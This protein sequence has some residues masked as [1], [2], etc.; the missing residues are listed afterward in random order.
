MNSSDEN[1]PSFEKSRRCYKQ[2]KSETGT[3]F[4]IIDNGRS[5]IEIVDLDTRPTRYENIGFTIH[6]GSSSLRFFSD[7]LFSEL[8]RSKEFGLEPDFTVL[9]LNDAICALKEGTNVFMAL[10]VARLDVMQFSLLFDLFKLFGVFLL[11]GEQKLSITSRDLRKSNNYVRLPL[12]AYKVG[13]NS[14]EELS[15][16]PDVVNFDALYYYHTSRCFYKRFKGTKED[17]DLQGLI[18]SQSILSNGLC[19]LPPTIFSMRLMQSAKFQLEVNSCRERIFPTFYKYESYDTLFIDA[20]TISKRKLFVQIGTIMTDVENSFVRIPLA[21]NQRW[22]PICVPTCG[23]IYFYCEEGSDT[24]CTV[25]I[26]LY[27]TAFVANEGTD[28]ANFQDRPVPK[29]VR[30]TTREDFIDCCSAATSIWVSVVAE[31]FDTKKT[32]AIWPNCDCAI[33]SICDLFDLKLTQPIYVIFNEICLANRSKL[34]YPVSADYQSLLKLSAG[35]VTL[36]ST[37]STILLNLSPCWENLPEFFSDLPNELATLYLQLNEDGADFVSKQIQSLMLHNARVIIT[38][39][40]N[41][42]KLILFK[43]RIQYFD[44]FERGFSLFYILLKLFDWDK[45]IASFKHLPNKITV[46]EYFTD[47]A[48]KLD[49]N[50]NLLLNKFGFEHK[51]SGEEGEFTNRLVKF[52]LDEDLKIDFDVRWDFFPHL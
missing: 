9:N 50:I 12:N 5:N 44:F 42:R 15:L 46:E 30:P 21:Q 47:L 13:Y 3:S 38:E 26:C 33:T 24:E 11:R 52:E 27:S 7:Q 36:F 17:R 16:P 29:F 1:D 37:L 10:T 28:C 43:E 19:T 20:R 22:Q 48:E 34:S 49:C 18:Q 35:N 31:Y 41:E 32:N 45:I 51:E 4:T 2:R 40:Q 39:P 8:K 6:F 14:N 25:D 23:N